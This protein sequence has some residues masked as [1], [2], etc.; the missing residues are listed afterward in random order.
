MSFAPSGR[1]FEIGF[2][3]QRASIVEVGGGIRAYS[4]DGREVLE[5]YAREAICDA[6]HGAPLIPWPNRLAHGRYRFEGAEQQLALSEPA[7]GNAIHGL[8][9]WRPWQ[10]EQHEVASVVMLARL[11]PMTG[12]P[13]ALE[14]SIAYELG[15]HGLTVS[16]SATNVGTTRCPYGAGQHPYLSPGAGHTI[17]DC[18]L[19]LPAA[20][21]LLNEERH[22]VPASREPV[23]GTAFDYSSARLLA[24]ATLDDGFTDLARDGE[25]RSGRAFS[26]PTAAPSSCGPIA[27][28]RSCSC[29]AATRCRRVAGAAASPSSR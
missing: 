9:R 22:Q 27:D 18:S 28:T 11:H 8:L 2:D 4:H 17:D 7:R 12:Y 19:T 26:A 3:S 15:E 23:A 20:T 21:R 16:T 25:G 29:S 10:A 13:F 5:P 24:G 1:Q 14:L 6:A